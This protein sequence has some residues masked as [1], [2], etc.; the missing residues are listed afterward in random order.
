MQHAIDRVW[1]KLSEW[2]DAFFAMLPNL[3]VALLV[4][5]LFW[6][7][8]RL[9]QRLLDKGLRRTPLHDT[10]VPILAKTAAFVAT[11][12]G[13]I[14]ALGV[15]NLQEAAAS[16]LAGAGIVGL[17]LGLAFQDVAANYF[18]GFMLSLRR[19]LQVGDVVETHDHFGTVEKIE[20]RTT[21]IRTFEGQRVMI[22]NRKVFTESLTNFTAYGKRR[23]D[24]PVGVSYGDD[25]EKAERVTLEAV[26]SLDCVLE[27]E[28][29]TLFYE[30]F[31]S[32]SIDFEVRFWV[33]YG[34]HREYL[35]G[36]HRA[37]KAIKAAFD[38]HDITIPFPIRTLDFGIVG[39]ATLAEMLPRDRRS[40]GRS[41]GARGPAEGTSAPGG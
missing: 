24:L 40:N 14:I 34:S 6:G 23:V 35:E 26:R 41:S 4:I 15:L 36:R 11:V 22:P 3:A 32:S 20:L 5:L 9:I 17:A 21:W 30:G 33:R 2:G 28:P 16:L 29:P 38:E 1:G 12:V 37:V 27:D 10:A 25:L 13:L 19:P 31:G 8:G 39:G 18:A 7:L